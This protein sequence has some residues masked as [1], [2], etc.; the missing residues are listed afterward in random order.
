MIRCW[1]GSVQPFK[2][3]SASDAIPGDDHLDFWTTAFALSGCAAFFLSLI[4]YNFVDIDIWHQIALIRESLAAGYLLKQDPYAYVPTIRP[5]ID[6]EWGAG[7][8]AYVG[9]TWLGP[10]WILVLKFV[11]AFGT[12]AAC[13]LHARFRGTDLRLLA[14]SAPLAFILMYLGFLSTVRA[15]AYSFALTAVL[16]CLLEI[17]RHGVRNWIVPWLLV[18]PIWLNLHAGFVVGIGIVALHALE[19]AARRLPWRHL[20]IVI[21]A[22][23]LEIFINP[24]GFAYFRYLRRATFMA[25]PYSPEWA[26]F[27]T[28]GTPLAMAFALA[29]LVAVYS[30]WRAGWRGVTGIAILLATAIEGALHRKLIPLFAIA[31]LCYVPSYLQQT[32]IAT[33]W[34]AFCS[35]RRRFISVA[36]VLFAC[37]CSFA[38]LRERPWKL[39][40]PQ[41]LYPVGPVFYLQQQKFNGNL[42]VPFRIGAF[43]SWMLYPAVK[44]SLDSRYEV[45]YSDTV[46]K[47]I[48]DFY[49]GRPGWQTTLAAYPTDAVL[50]P[51]NAPVLRAFGWSGWH[52]VYKDRQFEIYLRPGQDLPAEDWSAKSFEGTFP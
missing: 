36:W 15:Q 29:L 26:S 47:Q 3:G 21:F 48:F 5:W 7:A 2:T 14:L 32:P 40:I 1:P 35:K 42:L 50:L 46:M 33:W 41:P 22:M 9:T 16:L 19:Q 28:L 43:V 8:L 45:T 20:L 38:A 34:L 11:A 37:S 10:R 4:A 31:W 6:H 30:V 17:D 39:S 44:V 24:Y 13:A 12:A 52:R 25:R 18:F 23:V 51:N 27:L 49:D